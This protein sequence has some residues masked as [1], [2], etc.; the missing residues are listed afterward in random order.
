MP[1]K[2]IKRDYPGGPTAPEYGNFR[3]KNPAGAYTASW[4]YNKD[5]K[6]ITAPGGIK[7]IPSDSHYDTVVKRMTS[8][9]SQAMDDHQVK[10]DAYNK[11]MAAVSK[12]R[13]TKT[14][15]TSSQGDMK[16]RG[17]DDLIAGGKKKKPE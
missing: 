5:T 12:P 8:D 10:K 11:E 13:R 4:K 6:A 17:T 14:I 3:M 9:Y 2:E 15:D 16:L 1:K 7:F